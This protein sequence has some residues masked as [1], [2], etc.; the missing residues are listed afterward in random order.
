MWVL[1]FFDNEEGSLEL[2]C[3]CPVCGGR[4]LVCVSIMH[5][6]NTRALRKRT[7][8]YQVLCVDESNVYELVEYV[9]LNKNIEST[10]CVL[11]VVC[12]IVYV[13][14]VPFFQV[15]YSYNSNYQSVFEESW[16]HKKKSMKRSVFMPARW[17]R[18]TLNVVIFFGTKYQCETLHSGIIVGD[19]D[20]ISRSHRRR[21]FWMN[22]N[23]ILLW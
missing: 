17:V 15:A 10:W 1:L 3:R 5:H 9:F 14:W 16:L 19:P 23:N 8:F 11:W 2:A 22:C 7:V 18:Q 12:T 20:W 4:G 13:F 21:P 6:A